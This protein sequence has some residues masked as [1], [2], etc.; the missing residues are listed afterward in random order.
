[1]SSIISNTFIQ[2]LIACFLFPQKSKE[3][4]EENAICCAFDLLLLYVIEFYL[5]NQVCSSFEESKSFEFDG[6][7]D[8]LVVAEVF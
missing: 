3:K 1:M 5:L 6:R 7:L 4:L 8:V 2:L